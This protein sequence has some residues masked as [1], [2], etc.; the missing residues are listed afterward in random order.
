MGV[1]TIFEVEVPASTLALAETFERAPE[2][3]VE[4]ERTVGDGGDRVLR[5]VRLSGVEIDRLDDLLAADRTVA[6]AERLG[7]GDG[8]VLFDVAF[9]GGIGGF[10]RSIFDRGGVVLRATGFEGVWTFRLRFADRG[11]V[12]AVFDDQFTAEYE[13]TVT[14]LYG[15]QES[16]KARSRL[17]RKQHRALDAAF[18]MGYYSVPRDVDLQEVGQRLDISRQA[19]SERL[20]RAHETLVAEHVGEPT[21]DR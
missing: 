14:R 2:L 11:D 18:D 19:V 4:L 15:S 9:D 3:T 6:S 21:E 20:R 1:A 10:A 7:D 5:F 8:P 16:P 13:A 12:S 17:T